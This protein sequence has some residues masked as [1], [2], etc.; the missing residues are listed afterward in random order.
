[1]LCFHECFHVNRFSLL[2]TSELEEIYFNK[3]IVYSSEE[4][5]KSYVF[6]YDKCFYPYSKT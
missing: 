4:T 2:I 1:M 5:Q 6:A 3:I